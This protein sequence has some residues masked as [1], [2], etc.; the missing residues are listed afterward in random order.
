MPTM[1]V[2]T[3]IVEDEVEG[4]LLETIRKLLERV[5]NSRVTILARHEELV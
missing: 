4:E 2:I 3:I 5:N 1:T